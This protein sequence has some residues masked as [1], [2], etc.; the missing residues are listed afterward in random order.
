MEL[1]DEL[2][3]A[4]LERTDPVGARDLL[5]S[6]LTGVRAAAGLDEKSRQDLSRQLE[7][8][9]RSGDAVRPTPAPQPVAQQPT[10]PTTGPAPRP[11]AF[12]QAPATPKRPTTP[13]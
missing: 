2:V 7:S 12:A 11:Q 5:Q 9:L 8:R 3:A 4:R 13:R 1:A 6:A 10:A